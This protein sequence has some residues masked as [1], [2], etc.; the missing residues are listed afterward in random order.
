MSPAPLSPPEGGA[1]IR[2]EGG[3]LNVPDNPVIPWIEGDGIGSDLWRAA[4]NVFDSAVE[5]AYGGGRRVAWLEVPAGEKAFA[6]HGDHLPEV[7]LDT[8]RE[9]WVAI[10]GPMTTPVGNGV[11]SPNVALRLRLGLYAS[12]R[13]V[14]YYPGAPSP[15]K[16]PEKL[17][18]VIFRENV[19]DVFTGIEWTSG[20][21]DA[22]KVIE[23]LGSEFGAEIPDKSGI[24]IKT[25]SP[26]GSKNL[27][28]KAIQYAVD[29]GRDSVTL[30]HKGNIMKYTEGA[31]RNWGYEL[32]EDEFGDATVSEAQLYGELDGKMPAGKVLIKDR[33]ADVVFQQILTRPEEYSVIAAPNLNGDYLSDACA[34]QVGGI[35]LAPG[36]NYGDS[37]AV[38]EPAH[39]SA[40]KHAGLDKANPG[41]L[42]LSGVMMFDYL[43]W[44]EVASLIERALGRTILAGTVTYDLARGMDGAT[45]LKCSEFGEAIVDNMEG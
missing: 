7:T 36:A 39:G 25:I 44:T 5:K 6:A 19:E 9:H 34:A 3:G 40:P 23:F 41:S 24:G 17:D 8:I 45:Q 31:F 32:A 38:F 42:I 14:K 12:A 26:Q 2:F 29:R 10:K 16:A 33:I 18:V 30:V 35:G 22:N 20:S 37:L 4:R 1:K 27:V 11:R 15:V 28:R 43:G 13:P 21:D